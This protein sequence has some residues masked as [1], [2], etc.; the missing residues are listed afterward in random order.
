MR[1]GID[2]G[3]TKTE[4]VAMDAMGEIRRRIRVSTPS[5]YT[6][7]L[8]NLAKLMKRLES[9]AGPIQTVGVGTPGCICP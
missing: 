7:L 1:M 3:G 5:D 6:K 2:L 9:E 4:V 8:A